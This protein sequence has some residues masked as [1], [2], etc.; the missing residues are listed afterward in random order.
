MG[1]VALDTAVKERS[2]GVTHPS[3]QASTAARVGL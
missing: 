2:A 3:R 1:E